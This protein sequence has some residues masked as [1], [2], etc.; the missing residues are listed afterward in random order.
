MVWLLRSYLRR[1]FEIFTKFQIADIQFFQLPASLQVGQN[2]LDFARPANFEL[3][4][5]G[6]E[7]NEAAPH[8]P[9]IP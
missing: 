1:R 8:F 7:E 2:G 6:W 3:L 5:G 4:K 9:P